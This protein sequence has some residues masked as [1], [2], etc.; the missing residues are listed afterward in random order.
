[1]LR[2][3]LLGRAPEQRLPSDDYRPAQDQRVYEG[4]RTAAVQ[5]LAAGHSVLLDAVH[6]Q[7][8]ERDAVAA[9]AASAGVPF[10]GLWLEAPAATLESRVEG[11]RGDASDA[12][13]AIVRR[14]QGYDLGAIGWRRVAADGPLDKVV[15]SCRRAVAEAGIALA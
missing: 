5:G 4:L 3:T 9:L 11:R 13:A 7:P 14:Q 12:T 6:A 15:E 8:G 2:K 1:M 10:A